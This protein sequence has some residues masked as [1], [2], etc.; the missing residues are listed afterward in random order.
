MQVLSVYLISCMFL[1][2][3][4]GDGCNKLKRQSGDNLGRNVRHRNMARKGKWVDIRKHRGDTLADRIVEQRKLFV[5]DMEN[6]K[7][8]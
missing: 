8:V 1:I 5:E 2:Q 3:Y 6:N 4:L 7:K